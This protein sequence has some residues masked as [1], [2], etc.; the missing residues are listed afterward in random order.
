MSDNNQRKIGVVLS[1]L[2]IIISTLIQ[3]IYTPLLIRYLGDSEYGLFSLVSSIIGYLTILDLGFGNAIVV[4]TSKYRANGEIEKEKKLY[5]M[6]K[7]IF[8]IIGIIASILGI[9]LFL[10]VNNLFSATMTDVELHKMKIMMLI[11]T[12]NLAITFPFSIYSAIITAYEKFTFLKLTSIF[13]SIIK[14]VI[15]IPLLF[16]GFKSIT[17]CLVITIINITILLMNY[18]YCYK[19]LNIK[20]K[21]CGF[22][23]V[24]FKTIF[25]YSFY[26]FLNVIVDKVNW[27]LD[28][29]ILGAVSGTVAVSIY[30]VASQINVLFINLSSTV[31]N[32]LLPKMSKLVANNAS[33]EQLT[34]E[35][36][37]IGRI[38]CFIIFLL[39]SGFCLVGKEFIKLWAGDNYGDSYYVA[40]LLII[41]AC[42][43]LIQNLALSICQALNKH[44]FRAYVTT[45]MAFIN[46]IISYFL[47]K[48]YGPIGTAFGTTI[49]I[50]VCNIIVLNIYYHKIVKLDMIKF[51][52]NIFRIIIPFTVPL[53]III[54]FKKFVYLSG[55]YGILIYGSIYTIL[56]CSVGYYFCMN[57]YEKSLIKGLFL[58]K[59]VK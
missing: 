38:Q 28:Q 32:V 5:G 52:K 19:K 30:S 35:L 43:P 2:S 24:L 12:F 46:A 26:I 22:D 41:P 57:N 29:F 3:I 16:L 42:I 23:K 44:K 17:L 48:L 31:S 39:A 40:I 8:I 25:A 45:I 11:L 51:W 50:V 54:L 21:Y 33:S 10:N 59:K 56:Y 36:V 7:V 47:A 55:I 4:F 27:S 34:D 58:R 53:T 37:K 20:I 15:M 18:F 14:P 9:I 49:A 13:N 6:F 1:Y